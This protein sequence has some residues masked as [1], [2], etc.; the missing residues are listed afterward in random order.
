MDVFLKS[1]RSDIMRQVRGRDTIPELVVRS[2]AHRLGYR[3]GLHG[4][5][6]PG[7]PDLVFRSR[8]K[9]IFVHGCFWHGHRCARG[10]RVPKSNRNYWIAKIMRNRV[11]DRKAQSSL[12]A[13]GW[14]TLVIWECQ[15]SKV[16]KVNARLRI[17]LG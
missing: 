12:R 2:M 1:K 17:F 13:M 8:K 10:S 6:L 3:F 4:A 11:R 16:V 15:L 7:V 5:K 9:A 14:S